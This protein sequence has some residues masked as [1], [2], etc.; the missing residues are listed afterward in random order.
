MEDCLDSD[1]AGEM[2]CEE[3]GDTADADTWQIWREITQVGRQNKKSPTL[4]RAPNFGLSAPT[5]Q[6]LSDDI[7]TRCGVLT[8]LV[9]VVKPQPRA[10]CILGHPRQ[11]KVKP[12]FLVNVADWS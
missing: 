2:L 10:D 6:E 4:T 11:T 3:P 8:E 12:G 7:N 5:V 9:T 1:Q